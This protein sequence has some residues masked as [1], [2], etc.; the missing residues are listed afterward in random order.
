MCVCV[1]VHLCVQKIST[2]NI[3]ETSGLRGE[4]KNPGNQN[5]SLSVPTP[6][7]N[8]LRSKGVKESLCFWVVI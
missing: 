2:K 8:E 5:P 6:V 7:W 4:K 1:L 3:M